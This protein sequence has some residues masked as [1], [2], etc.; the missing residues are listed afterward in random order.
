VKWILTREKDDAANDCAELLR[1]G[2]QVESVPCVEL[3]SQPWP[4]WR[5]ESGTR[6]TFL[7]SRRAARCYLEQPERIGLVAAVAPATSA[8]LEASRIAVE[9]SARGG[10]V[11]LA[12]AVLARWEER[13]RPPWHIVYPTSD[14]ALEAKEQTLALSILS[15]VGPVQREAVYANRVPAGLAAALETSLA[16]RWSA[17]FHSPSAVRALLAEAPPGATVPAH[18]VCFGRS[19]LD[20][21]NQGRRASWP[22]AVLSSSIVETITRLEEPPP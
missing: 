16:G 17:C 14:V 4:R 20:A 18:V 11:A 7:T 5:K 10:A 15:R 22:P 12:E 8:S 9:M 2:V 6:I 1:L 3:V 13:G 19:T 21:W